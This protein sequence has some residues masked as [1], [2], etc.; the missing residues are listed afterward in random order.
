MKTKE[1]IKAYNKEY[2]ARPEV[3]A[4][5]KIRNSQRRDKRREYKKT[6]N[7]KLAERRSRLKYLAKP[8]VKESLEDKHLRL[9]YGISKL[10]YNEMFHSQNGMCAICSTSFLKLHVDHSHK[11]GEV[12]GLLCGSCNRG[13]GLLKDNTEFLL[14]AIEY[15]NK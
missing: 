7:G 1:S 2:F 13:L 3:I 8:E 5:A 15:L 12:R 6:K 14:K 11:T 4:R 10:D 9:R